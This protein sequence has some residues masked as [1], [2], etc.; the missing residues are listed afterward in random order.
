MQISDIY[1][2]SQIQKGLWL[3]KTSTVNMQHKPD[4]G[5]MKQALDTTTPL[6]QQYPFLDIELWTL[7]L[8]DGPG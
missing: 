6:G 8:M 5:S 3:K 2:I 7:F 1:K 4:S